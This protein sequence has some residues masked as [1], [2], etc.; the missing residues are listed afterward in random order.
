VL[1]PG[2]VSLIVGQLSVLCSVDQAYKPVDN[3]EGELAV[4][5]DKNEGTNVDVAW[6]DRNRSWTYCEVKLTEAKFGGAKGEERHH[7]KLSKTYAPLLCDHCPPKLLESTVFFA[8]DQILRNV[9]LAA[10][11]SEGR[12]LFLMPKQN[13]VLWGPLQTILKCLVSEL[14][15]RIN[16]ISIEEV[17]ERL[18]GDQML[19][20]ELR[21]HASKLAEK[22]VLPPA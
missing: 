12:V 7:L 3:V 16:V 9:W 13:E 10:R 21:S 17:L 1:E 15:A 8:N 2:T 22:Y 19:S 5:V 18:L 4:V 20:S 14:R 6:Q 11:D